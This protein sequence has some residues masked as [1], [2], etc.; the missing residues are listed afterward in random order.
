MELLNLKT[1]CTL[2][3]QRKGLEA[4]EEKFMRMHKISDY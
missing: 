1:L 4:I 3:S 2:Y